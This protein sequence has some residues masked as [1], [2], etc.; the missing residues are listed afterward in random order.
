MAHRKMQVL[1]PVGYPHCCVLCGA[2]ENSGRWFVDLGFDI[3]HRF[4]AMPDGAVYFCSECAR[5]FVQRLMTIIEQQEMG[6][7]Y[8]RFGGNRTDPVFDEYR[9]SIDAIEQHSDEHESNSDDE[10]NSTPILTATFGG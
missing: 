10:V 4:D 8:V 6:L 1:P 7:D 5:D 9:Q 3:D 2:V